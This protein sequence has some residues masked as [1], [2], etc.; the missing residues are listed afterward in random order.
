[1]ANTIVLNEYTA[2]IKDSPKK[3]LELG[4]CGSYGHE[5]I[6]II[7]E[8]GWEDMSVYVTFISPKK[9]KRTVLLTDSSILVPKDATDLELLYLPVT[10]TELASSLAIFLIILSLIA[11]SIS[12][13]LMKKM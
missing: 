12:M 6:S 10:K 2:A 8:A 1:M 5:R 11:A 3:Y 7:Q 4:T 13:N 9:V